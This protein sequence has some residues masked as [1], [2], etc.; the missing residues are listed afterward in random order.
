MTKK[1]TKSNYK[2]DTLYAPVARA[3]AEIMKTEDAVTTIGV[4]IKLQRI[5]KQDH[6][7]WRFGRIPY[8]ERT[9]LGSLGKANRIVRI[10][11]LHAESLHL[12]ASQTAYRR[13]GK[14]KKHLTLRFS[15][16]GAPH[17]ER[18][19]ATH[20]L[21][22]SRMEERTKQSSGREK[23]AVRSRSLKV[24]KKTPEQHPGDDKIVQ[25]DEPLTF[26]DI[27]F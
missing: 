22:K 9:F 20:Y 19:Y 27:P 8:L 4:M 14:G 1:I 10:V 2:K 7:N 3:I 13:W 11:K 12:V 21:I 23:V 24:P 18:A 5:S 15:K 16:W 25:H 17:L 26:D 6:E